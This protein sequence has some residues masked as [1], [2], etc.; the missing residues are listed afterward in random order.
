MTGWL[1]GA[2]CRPPPP[3]APPW[4]R[5]QL[6]TWLLTRRCLLR[7][8]SM[9]AL[10]RGRL[11]IMGSENFRNVG[12]YQ[13]VLIMTDPIISTRTRIRNV[14]KSQPIRSSDRHIYDAEIVRDAMRGEWG[15]QLV[16]GMTPRPAPPRSGLAAGVVRHAWAGVN[17]PR[18]HKVDRQIV[19]CLGALHPVRDVMRRG[20]GIVRSQRMT[21]RASYPAWP[22]PWQAIQ[23]DRWISL[24]GLHCQPK[25]VWR[26]HA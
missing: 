9:A 16:P 4:P 25:L 1:T 6:R 13:R 11:E 2:A 19:R 24:F 15:V 22:T 23:A 18:P 12:K 26:T 8:I 3:P 21:R 10:I 20:H 7:V 17:A 14:G 5:R